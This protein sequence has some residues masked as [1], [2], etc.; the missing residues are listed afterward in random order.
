MPFAPIPGVEQIGEAVIAEARDGPH[1]RIAEQRGEPAFARRQAP[2]RD[3][4]I[5]ADDEAAQFVRGVEPAADILERSAMT[6][7]R[8]RLEID[9][10][11]FDRSGGDR[12]HELVALAIYT[13]V[14]D[15]TAGIVQDHEA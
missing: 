2:D 5:G 4:G 12:G 13:G 14:A 7:E 8:L 1:E 15:G 10:A 9:V 6:R 3:R 11:K